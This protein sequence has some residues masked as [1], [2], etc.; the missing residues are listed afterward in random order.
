MA[1]KNLRSQRL[2]G[3]LLLWL[4]GEAPDIHLQLS[5]L[6]QLALAK[7]ETKKKK[8]PVLER[9]HSHHVVFSPFYMTSDPVHLRLRRAAA[10]KSVKLPARCGS[11]DFA[12][13]AVP[14]DRPRPEDMPSIIFWQYLFKLHAACLSGF[15]AVIQARTIYS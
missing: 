1:D 11:L 13:L 14:P 12:A 3:L 7:C 6:F 8:T 2:S 4:L 10:V 5:G 9:H 15:N